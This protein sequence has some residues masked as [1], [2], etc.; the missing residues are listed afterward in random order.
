MKTAEQLARYATTVK[1][2][3]HAKALVEGRD[4]RQV[5]RPRLTDKERLI[6]LARK[7]RR[8]SLASL[9]IKKA[10]RAERAIKEGRAP[11]QIGQPPILTTEERE[12]SRKATF[13]NWQVRNRDKV[14][15][16]SRNRRARIRNVGGRHTAED[17]KRLW[18]LQKGKCT[19][20]LQA[21]GEKKPHVDHRMPISKGGSNDARN[22][23]LLHSKCNLQKHNHNPE[24]FGLRHGLLAW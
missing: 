23:Q 5:G 14:A 2:K 16:I 22:L 17:I 8:D 10:R 18:F 6:S 1:A 24:D 7:R 9:G 21:L 4:P 20:C 11:G 15:V 3:L 12:K 13:K 19:W